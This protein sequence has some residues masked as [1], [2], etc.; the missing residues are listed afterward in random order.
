M[1]RGGGGLLEKKFSAIWHRH[2]SKLK[3]RLAQM[4]NMR[5]LREL[6]KLSRLTYCMHL[7]KIS[8]QYGADLKPKLKVSSQETVR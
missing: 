1:G 7:K 4:V 2:K 6:L 8:L 5:Y 3:L